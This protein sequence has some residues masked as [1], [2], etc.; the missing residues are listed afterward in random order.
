MAGRGGVSAA[1][2]ATYCARP[3]ATKGR[4]LNDYEYLV[5]SREAMFDHLA[6]WGEA[7]KAAR[8]TTGR[9]TQLDDVTN[10]DSSKVIINNSRAA[11]SVMEA[12]RSSLPERA[13]RTRRPCPTSSVIPV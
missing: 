12:L 9:A 13:R 6:W 2:P 4:S 10:G 11:N 5:Q 8:Q 1:R 7:L 3:A